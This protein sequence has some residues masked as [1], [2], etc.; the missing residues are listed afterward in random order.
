M[1]S[2][3]RGGGTNDTMSPPLQKEEGTSPPCPPLS[4]TPVSIDNSL[5]RIDAN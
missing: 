3:R 5:D 1:T 2:K 4:D